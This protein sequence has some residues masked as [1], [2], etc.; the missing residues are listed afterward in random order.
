MLTLTKVKRT[1]FC[2]MIVR[3]WKR[4]AVHTITA[5]ILLYIYLNWTQVTKTMVHSSDRRYTW[6]SE[7]RDV[8]AVNKERM[9]RI[10]K[11][12]SANKKELRRY[13]DMTDT[14]KHIYIDE[15][16]KLTYCFLLKSGYTFWS[17]LFHIVRGDFNT[18]SPFD[19]A[20]FHQRGNGIPSLHT[21]PLKQRSIFFNSSFSFMFTRD[22]YSRLLSGY[23][24]KLFMPNNHWHDVAPTIGEI[25][26]HNHQDCIPD[27]TFSEF[28]KY[29]IHSEE[30][31]QPRNPH[32]RFA[33][34]FCDPCQYKYKFIGK[35][36]TIKQDTK[37]LLGKMNQNKIIQ[38]L[39]KDFKGQYTNFTIRERIDILFRIKDIYPACQVKF[40]QVQQKI[41]KG[42]Q[43]N[44]IIST[45]SKYPITEEQSNA[46][47]PD[48]FQDFV[49]KA[50]GD[51]ADEK[52][53]RRNK[54]EAML[55][56]YSTVETA[57]MEKL[58]RL[59]QS[60]CE[61]FG[62]DCRP[63]KL[64]KDRQYIKPWYFDIATA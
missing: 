6:V 25:V 1:S 39:E 31:R 48:I 18:T 23:T 27:L 32:F 63:S 55:E 4:T 28:I 35:L 49:F 38:S 56:A 30:H 33:F 20:I 37:Y 14:S 29:I 19:P 46:I 51:A 53:S 7:H 57:D 8:S 17:I 21:L 52:V 42:F 26:R 58:S 11:V 9:E 60:D 50:I 44:G 61:V 22:P 41:W 59:L 47:T 16:H 40:F 2:N 62:Y 64:F 36:E 45:S 13:G 12:C 5:V 10:H 15:K 3:R 43:M 34:E 24:D 54:E